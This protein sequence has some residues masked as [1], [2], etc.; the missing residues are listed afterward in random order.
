MKI[1]YVP[2]AVLWMSDVIM[3]KTILKSFELSWERET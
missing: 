1:Y 3:K 2:G